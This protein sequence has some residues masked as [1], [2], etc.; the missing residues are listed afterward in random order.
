MKNYFFDL[1][2]ES[3]SSLYGWA[4]RMLSGRRNWCLFAQNASDSRLCG[5]GL[6][7]I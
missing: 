5:I 3:D 2:L 6:M 4:R 1:S 7:V